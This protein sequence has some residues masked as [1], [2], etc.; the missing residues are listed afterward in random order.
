MTHRIL[1]AFIFVLFFASIS[2]AQVQP[3]CSQNPISYRYWTNADLTKF[4]PT[5]EIK[6]GQARVNPVFAATGNS[7]LDLLVPKNRKSWA[8]TMAFVNKYF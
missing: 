7:P 4:I 3:D 8:M 5:G 6:L 1:I 2:L